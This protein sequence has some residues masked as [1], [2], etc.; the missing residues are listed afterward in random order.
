MTTPLR[1]TQIWYCIGRRQYHFSYQIV[2]QHGTYLLTNSGNPKKSLK[3]NDLIKRVKNKE[4]W[5]Q[6]K[7]SSTKLPLEASE[8]EQAINLMEK[9]EDSSKKLSCLQI[10]IQHDQQ[11]Q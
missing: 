7:P 1:G 11:D 10:P 3:I 9:H 4:V 8:W 5:H 6:R 2:S